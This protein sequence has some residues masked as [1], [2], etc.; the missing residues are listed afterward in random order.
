M[1]ISVCL[2]TYQGE[3]FIGQQL[4]SI[5]AQLSPEDEVVI[6]DDCS[7]DSTREIIE[8]YADPRIRVF[9]NAT[10]VGYSKNFE[11][12]LSHANG[13][14]IFIS[15]Q[16]DVWLPNKV[17]LMRDSLLTHDLVVSDVVVVDADLATIA[18]SHFRQYG[19]K[20]GFAHNLVRTRYIGAAMAMRRAV[21]DVALPLPGRSSL[22]AYDYWI[23][24]AGELFF[25]VDVLDVP[26]MLYRRHGETAST[27]GA[28]STHSIRHRIAVRA[29]CLFHLARRA[30]RGWSAGRSTR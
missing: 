22:C 12:A 15:D 23:A 20:P 30:R 28:G 2:A 10:N 13:D 5:L 14:I 3:R 21:L 7:S 18:P 6:S 1:K 19:V 4:D 29:Y 27:G 9:R 17:E 11:N 8:S 26:L 16:D 25:R 24:I